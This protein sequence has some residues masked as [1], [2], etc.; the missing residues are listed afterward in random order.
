MSREP[1]LNDSIIWRHHSPFFELLAWLTMGSIIRP[2]LLVVRRQNV[3]VFS[4]FPVAR[5]HSYR[6]RSEVYFMQSTYYCGHNNMW[7]AVGSACSVSRTEWMHLFLLMTPVLVGSPL[8]GPGVRLC[9]YLWNYLG[10]HC[11]HP[12][13]SLP[14][15][16]YRDLGLHLSGS[17]NNFG[18]HCPASRPRFHQ[19]VFVFANSL[20]LSSSL[21]QVTITSIHCDTYCGIVG[22]PYSAKQ[23]FS[24]VNLSLWKS[25]LKD[26]INLFL[27]VSDE[28]ISNK[29][30]IANFLELR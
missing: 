28:K 19:N 7:I 14:I 9:Q 6:W 1:I 27:P 10:L 24:V 5:T 25:C 15:S 18:L 13:W 11:L 22:T 16:L 30:L 8:F 20:S 3:F 12:V 29:M 2:A 4:N 23:L 21:S 17:C 26:Y